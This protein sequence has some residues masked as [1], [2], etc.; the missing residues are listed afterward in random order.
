L[1]ALSQLTDRSVVVLVNPNT[2]EGRYRTPDA[3]K[4]LLSKL[5]QIQC[6]VLVDESFL[7][8]VG[9]EA[10]KSLRPQI[11][12][13]PKLVI[14]QSLTKYYACPG[15]RIG[16]LFS[17]ANSLL[18]CEWAS[19]PISVLDEHYLRQ[20]LQDTQ[21]PHATQAFL[22]QERDRFSQLL[23]NSR[24]I[25][26]VYPATA[27]FVLVKTHVKAQVLVQALSAFN[28]LIRDCESFGL[29]HNHCRIAIKSQEENDTFLIAL[30]QIQENTCLPEPS[31]ECL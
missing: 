7:P 9:F 23:A 5:A 20:A 4:A 11:V 15:V 18:Q 16:A 31:E 30:M 13:N 26:S 27:N 8:F 19:W 14:L 2:P 24:L 25:Q 12:D 10:D 22:S 6:W 3:L 28:I 21:H 17:Q 1:Q 29:G